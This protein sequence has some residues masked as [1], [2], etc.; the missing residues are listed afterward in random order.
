MKYS[1][2]FSAPCAPACPR[3]NH[4]KPNFSQPINRETPSW[5]PAPTARSP[6]SWARLCH[7]VDIKSNKSMYLSEV[8]WTKAFVFQNVDQFFLILKNKF[9]L[10]WSSF[11]ARSHQ[12]SSNESKIT[13]CCP[14]TQPQPTT[15]QLHGT[16]FLVLQIFTVQQIWSKN[17]S[18][19]LRVNLSRRRIGHKKQRHVSSHEDIHVFAWVL[20]SQVFLV[21]NGCGPWNNGKEVPRWGLL[22]YRK[23]V[24]QQLGDVIVVYCCH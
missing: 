20:Y 16:G 7:S 13:N 9:T 22:G 5:L 23:W 15:A 18:H 1:G 14:P 4:T 3:V 11:T 8:S 2:V 17:K 24:P 19:E 12:A 6:A 21:V 10:H